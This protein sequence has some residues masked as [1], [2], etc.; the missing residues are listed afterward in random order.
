MAHYCG[1]CD[2]YHDLPATTDAAEA[3]LRVDDARAD[4]AH[5][6]R[7]LRTWAALTATAGIGTIVAT[8]FDFV[9]LIVVF[10]ILTV[11]GVITTF[12]WWDH[13]GQ[14]NRRTELRARSR[15]Y[16]A[17]VTKAVTTGDPEPE[18]KPEGSD[19]PAGDDHQPVA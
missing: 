6:L 14:G 2:A 13:N 5:Y 17:Q 1:H 19:G 8:W 7:W 16:H 10:A 15:I 3:L 18:T 9:G 4:L 12:S 11:G